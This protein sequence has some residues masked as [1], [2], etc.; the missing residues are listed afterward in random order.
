MIDRT[1]S[2]SAVQSCQLL[3]VARS[4]AYYQP[5]PVAGSELALLRRI[6]ELH[7][8]YR[9]AVAQ[10]LRNLLREDSQAIWRRCVAS[11]FRRMGITAVY[12][13]PCTTQRH[14]AH[15]ICPLISCTD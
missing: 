15:R 10:I 6:D 8:R 2:L 5:T 1:H 7:L 9:F 4:M 3:G 14:S 11:L 12:R 13:M